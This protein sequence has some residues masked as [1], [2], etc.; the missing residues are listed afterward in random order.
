MALGCSWQLRSRPPN[1][2]APRLGQAW[3]GAAASAVVQF[4]PAAR[5]SLVSVTSSCEICRMASGASPA[6]PGANEPGEHP[7]ARGFGASR[8][9]R[10]ELGLVIGLLVVIPAALL[11]GARGLAELVAL[12]LPPALDEQIGMPT[13]ES[14]KLS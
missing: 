13:W 7:E 5:R 6:D 9:P 11:W 12:S 1:T 10:W 8:R 2:F 14:L 4:V 3:L